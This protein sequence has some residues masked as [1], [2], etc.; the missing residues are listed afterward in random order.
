MSSEYED[1][2]PRYIPHPMRSGKQTAPSDG[3]D[4]IDEDIDNDIVIT[5]MRIS[6]DGDIRVEISTEE[7]DGTG[8]AVKTS[9][10]LPAAG[11]VVR[12]RSLEEGGLIKVP[13]Y[14]TVKVVCDTDTAGGEDFYVDIDAFE[15]NCE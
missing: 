8:T 7:Q 5:R 12:E 11:E 13:G 2:Y 9:V 1:Y 6:G 14:S 10:Y 3:D 4:L 15:I